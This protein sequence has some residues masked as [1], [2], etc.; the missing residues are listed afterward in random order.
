[1]GIKRGVFES[2]HPN[3]DVARPAM[4]S[5]I[6]PDDYGAGLRAVAAGFQ[7]TADTL[8][9]IADMTGKGAALKQA[10]KANMNKAAEAL[11]NY[12]LEVAQD[13]SKRNDKLRKSLENQAALM[14][15]TYDRSGMF[16]LWGTPSIESGRKSLGL[17]K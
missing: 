10:N 17:G 16:G 7:A 6:R 4:K 2:V 9:K 12:D 15:D 14:K 11:R 3:S 1:M 13:P 5:T 8:G